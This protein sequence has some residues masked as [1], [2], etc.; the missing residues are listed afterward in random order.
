LY[1]VYG[2]GS[3]Q[4]RHTL[5]MLA[6]QLQIYVNARQEMLTGELVVYTNGGKTA[7]P[8]PHIAIANNAVIHAIKLMNELGLTPKSRLATNKTQD[9]KINDFLSGPKFGT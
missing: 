3:A 6:D 2:I 9:K 7:A 1:Q 8:N 5:I 4:D